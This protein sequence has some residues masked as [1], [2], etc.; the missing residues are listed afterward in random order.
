VSTPA[1]Q[2]NTPDEQA[3]EG[4]PAEEQTAP[5]GAEQEQTPEAEKPAE[6]APESKD[7]ELPDWARS[8]LSRVRSEAASYRTKLREAEAKLEGA[9][10]P[11]EFEAAVTELKNTNATLERSLTVTKVAAKHQLPS[12]LAELLKGDTEEELAA[13]AKVLAKFA[14][15][16]EIDP[17]DLSG[18]LT[19]GGSD[20]AF[21]PV[22]AARKARQRRI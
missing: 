13:H 6:E 2:T 14:P 19:P 7:A 16:T 17:D 18:G 11:E 1:V 22:A 3:P 5:E 21:D 8:E 15:A 20:A 9:K 4:Q 10:T 12:E